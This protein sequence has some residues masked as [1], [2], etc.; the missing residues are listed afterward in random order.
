MAPRAFDEDG[1]TLPYVEK[2]DCEASLI[3]G[4][5][6]EPD[7][8]GSETDYEREPGGR[9]QTP[10]RAP[11]KPAPPALAMKSRT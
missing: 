11:L 7:E 9:N 10:K 3:G 2:R 4:Q 6:D 1:V 8:C 5:G